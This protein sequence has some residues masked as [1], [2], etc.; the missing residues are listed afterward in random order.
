MQ[1]LQER[2]ISESSLVKADMMNKLCQQPFELKASQLDLAPQPQSSH[3]VKRSEPELSAQWSNVSFGQQ[4][5]LRQETR[6]SRVPVSSQSNYQTQGSTLISAQYKSTTVNGGGSFGKSNTAQEYFNKGL[7]SHSLGNGKNYTSFVSSSSQNLTRPNG[8]FTSE[9]TIQSGVFSQLDSLAKKSSAINKQSIAKSSQFI[10]VFSSSQSNLQKVI[11]EGSAAK[12]VTQ[13][14]EQNSNEKTR[15]VK[16]VSISNTGSPTRQ[17]QNTSHKNVNLKLTSKPVEIMNITAS[18]YQSNRQMVRASSLNAYHTLQRVATN[19]SIGRSKIVAT[20]VYP[21]DPQSRKASYLKTDKPLASSIPLEF[22]QKVTQNPSIIR[23]SLYNRS[24]VVKDGSSSCFMNRADDEYT[25]TYESNNINSVNEPLNTNTSNNFV[26][27]SSLNN[28]SDVQ[29]SQKNAES[30]QG[31][32]YSRVSLN[33]SNGN[34]NAT[35]GNSLLL[36][37]SN[38][39]MKNDSYLSTNNYSS[40]V[41]KQAVE[42]KRYDRMITAPVNNYT[43]V[44]SRQIGYQNQS[45]TSTARFSDARVVSQPQSAT[46]SFVKTNYVSY[47]RPNGL[48]SS[49]VRSTDED[50]KESISY[51]VSSRQSIYNPKVDNNQRVSLNDSKSS[52]LQSYKDNIRKHV[53]NVSNRGVTSYIQTN[54]NSSMQTLPYYYSSTPKVATLISQTRNES[55]VTPSQEKEIRSFSHLPVRGNSEIDENQEFE[56]PPKPKRDN[57]EKD[58]GD[59]KYLGDHQQNGKQSNHSKANVEGLNLNRINSNDKKVTDNDHY[60]SVNNQ[61]P[62]ITL[63]KLLSDRA[64]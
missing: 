18:T 5:P 53:V 16:K 30:K 9:K 61:Q 36:N 39:Y 52:N 59:V 44:S 1:K 48:V 8:H 13:N 51:N 58:N 62:D 14:V 43:S 24:T 35:L 40:V 25:L 26:I 33:Q 34:Q 50:M 55:F 46:G 27:H 47:S 56:F 2:T 15:T 19:Q 64:I 49:F 28:N 60:I 45:K 12:K 29:K 38:H 7:Q 57:T 10:D 3:F 17:Q 6:I 20:S 37:S 23:S 4:E 41:N 21:S 22:S 54:V 32:Y 31:Q 63:S 11:K 42:G